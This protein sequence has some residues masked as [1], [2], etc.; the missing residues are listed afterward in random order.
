MSSTDRQNR[1]LLA[2]DWK[3]IYQTYRNADFKNYDFDNLRRTMIN[4]LR[5]NYPEDF[6]DYIESSEYIALIDLIAYLGQNIAFRIDLNARENFLELAERRESILRLARLINYNPKRNIAASGLLKISAVNTTESV[7]DSNNVNLRDQT[8]VW[9]DATNPNWYEQFIKILNRTFSINENFGKPVQKSTVNGV[10]T[11]TYRII[12]NDRTSIPVF[13]F[14]R[15]VDGNNL[16]CEIVSTVI[17]TNIVEEAPLPGNNFS[18]LYRNDSQGAGSS[19]TGFFS[20]FKQGSLDQGS[21][22]ITNPISNQIVSIDAININNSD[23]W[24]YSLNEDMTFGALWNKVDALQGNNVIYNSLA[25]DKKNIYTILTRIDDKISLI[26]SDGVFGNLPYGNFQTYFRASRNDNIVISPRDFLGL[27]IS[28]PYT[29]RTGKLETITLTYELL[30]TVDNAVTSET[31][32]SIKQN[33]PAAYYTQ[34]RLITAEDYQVGLLNVNQEIVKTKSVNRV[35]SGISRYFDLIDST[36]KYSKTNLFGIDGILYKESLLQSQNFTFETKTDIEGII[37]NTIEPL[38]SSNE[39]FNFYYN[40]YTKIDVSD[41]NIFWYQNTQDT[42]ICTGYFENENKVKQ[43][44][45]SATD[46]ILKNLRAGTSVKF[47]APEGKHF[48]ADNSHTLMTGSADHANSV[49]YKWVKII[50]VDG[51]G[52]IVSTDGIGPIVLNDIIPSGSKLAVILPSVPKTLLSDVKTQIVDQAFAYQTFGL[53]FDRDLRQWKLI[54]ESNLDVINAFSTGKTG[55]VSNQKLDNSWLFKFT[56]D[57]E[58]YTMTYRGSKYVFESENE[59]RFYFDSSEKIY[60]NKTG[61]IV[62][63]KITILN[64]NNKPNSLDKFTVDFDWSIVSEYRDTAGY[65]NTNKV[66]IG[67]F[68]S[69]DDGVADNPEIYDEII[70]TLDSTKI[71]F[72]KS[73]ITADGVEDFN[74]VDNSVEKIKILDNK[75]AIG[76]LSQYDTGQKFYFIEEDIFE[77]FNKVTNVLSLIN[78]YKAYYGRDK[79]RF[80]Y[81]HNADDNSRIDPSISNIIDT[82][83]LTRTYDR[84]FRQFLDGTL[85][86]KPL[87]ASNDQLYNLFSSSINNIKSLTDE[88]IY[89]PAKYRILFGDKAELNLQATFKIVKN[90]DIVVDNNQIKTNIVSAINQYFALENWDFGETFYFSELSS[91]IMQQ[92]APNIVTLVIVPKQ[93][94]QGFGSLFEIKSETDE[95]FVSGAT[96]DNIEIIDAVTASRLKSSG[97]IVTGIQSTNAGIQST[98]YT[99]AATPE[100]SVSPT[101]TTTATAGGTTYTSTT[102]SSSSG[103]SSSGSSSSSSSSSSYSY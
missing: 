38:L 50:S 58:K 1:L 80:Q 22:T 36:G 30:Y 21:F 45:G 15:T 100:V 86:S 82:Y 78:N 37:A 23:V 77:S 32:I 84:Q 73:E 17:D 27:T 97:V 10:P 25:K 33:A 62:K 75:T 96:V 98:S 40:E 41:L 47:I 52:I 7:I 13:P 69:D 8:I 70:G 44:L 61:K 95:I 18:I 11:E 63:D 28:I 12:T 76:P 90:P 94:N 87:P 48:M 99:T 31:N 54:T 42:N 102:T 92:L 67:F 4:Y 64:N 57:N 56:N 66:E 91:F 72:Q 20:L 29:S 103:S 6:N 3:R 85:S 53:R 59:I 9:N 79:I 65:V 49:T 19:N 5:D 89:H 81:V 14:N 35:A 55:D 34:N 2:E 93:E 68:D 74:Y 71:I 88:V 101:A 46:G 26:F 39:I 83:L 24:L 51:T 43:L 16:K 60:N